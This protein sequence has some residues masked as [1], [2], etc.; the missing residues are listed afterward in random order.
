MS[1]P[2]NDV[3]EART[4]FAGAG[5]P[6]PSMPPE[7]ESTFR[8]RDRWCYATREVDHWPNEIRWYAD[9]ARTDVADYVLLAH[10][11]HGVNS[12]AIH[13]YLVRGPLGVFGQAPWGG[14]YMEGDD[15][16]PTMRE[17]FELAEALAKAGEALPIDD[18]SRRL[19]VFVS[20]FYGSWWTEPGEAEP[21]EERLR[22]KGRD[23]LQGVLA[24]VRERQ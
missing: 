22:T 18:G 14:V 11:G 23:V 10:A 15:V 4:L 19:V 7:M 12:Y 9:E 24:W 21:S 3:A 6:F 5:L 2:A 17:Y 16:I 8:K 20:D 13:Y 1:G